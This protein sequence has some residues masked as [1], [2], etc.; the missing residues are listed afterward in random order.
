MITLK[1]IHYSLAVA[2]TLNFRKAADECFVSPSALSNA[3]TEMEKI[4][5]IRVF[6]RDNK[7]VLLTSF[8]RQFCETAQTIKL[9]IKD[10]ESLAESHK[11]PLGSNLS[12]GIIPTICPYLLPIVLPAINSQYPDLKITI[13]E[14]QSKNLIDNLKNGD[15]DI[16]ILA[17]QTENLL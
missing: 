15:I 5:G 4:L 12:M 7:R 14:G 2:K 17:L 10:I 11:A 8:G 13:T 6:E 16:A 1:Q 9:Q 3:L